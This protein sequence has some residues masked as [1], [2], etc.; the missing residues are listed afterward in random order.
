MY[1][2]YKKISV[3]III[4]LIIYVC[5]ASALIRKKSSPRLDLTAVNDITQTLAKNWEDV[6]RE[7]LP[8]LHYG[9][10][11]VVIDNE[12]Y[13]I[14]ATKGGLNEDV[15]TALSNRDTIINIVKD[16]NILGKLILYN[17]INDEWNKKR[18]ELLVIAFVIIVAV[19]VLTIIL[20][21]HINRTIF[22]PFNRLKEFARHVAAGNLD[23]PLTMDKHN[24]FG[25]FSESFDLMR[26]ELKK[27]RESERAANQ[28]KKELVAS[29][30]HDIKTPVASIMA[31][32]EIMYTKCNDSNDKEQLQVIYSKSEQIDTLI[33]N[34]FTATLEELH[35]L[36]VT[37]TEQPS[38]IIN[39]L[40]K[41]SDYNN[42]VTIQC[43]GECIV[44]MDE[45]RLSQIIDN[46]IS[47]SYKYA[48]TSIS[49]SIDIKDEVL[50]VTF[51]DYGKGVANKEIPLL[52]N[53]FYRAKN[54]EGKS[55]A[56]LGL[57]ISRYLM[58]KMSGDIICDNTEAGFVVRLRLMLA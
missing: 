20:L 33:T 12:G 46:I 17:D 24:I 38:N 8:G 1:S 43:N 42:R 48:A 52:F 35:E 13:F 5:V 6:E 58:T 14:A 31:V 10:D 34:M 22:R 7:M 54:S 11:Y 23:L 4:I 32:S 18:I 57:Y 41:R 28:S 16:H 37:V 2:R 50:E 30:S 9:Y 39:N 19:A 56:G 49:V 26:E 40:I 36:E 44:L 53:K 3:I 27:A 55:G 45:L 25:A 47:N 15:N 21:V 29:L 51:M